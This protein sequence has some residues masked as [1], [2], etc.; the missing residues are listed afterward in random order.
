MAKVS[1]FEL[2]GYKLEMYTAE[3]INEP[4]QFNC[5]DMRSGVDLKVWVNGSGSAGLDYVAIRP[6]PLR[7]QRPA[8]DAGTEKELCRLI[9]KHR[10]ELLQQWNDQLPPQKKKGLGRRKK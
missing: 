8:I 4:P 6:K 5:K 7:T 9:D 3:D 1:A 2:S 10:P